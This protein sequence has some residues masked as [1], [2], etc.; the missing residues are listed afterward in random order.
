MNGVSR[1]LP[2]RA[3]APLRPFLPVC[4]GG[5]AERGPVPAGEWGAA[6]G[7][8]RQVAGQW[9]RGARPA[10]VCHACSQ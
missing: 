4:R 6:G 1:A 5:G 3:L 10:C 9:Q 2:V 7:G 8:G